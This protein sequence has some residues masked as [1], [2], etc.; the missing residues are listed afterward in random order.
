MLRRRWKSSVSTRAKTGSG[1]VT[2]GSTITYQLTVQ[3]DG[4]PSVAQSV[5]V[6]DTLPAEVTLTSASAD[7]GSCTLAGACDLGDIA[8]GDTVTIDFTGVVA[9]DTAAGTIQNRANVFHVV[10]TRST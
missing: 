3:N 1:T 5:E 8:V 6:I 10:S 7:Q 9:A 4:G 2:A